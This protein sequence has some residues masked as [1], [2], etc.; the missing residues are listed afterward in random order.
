MGE[1]NLNSVVIE[2]AFIACADLLGILY[3]PFHLLG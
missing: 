1:K 2:K 3:L